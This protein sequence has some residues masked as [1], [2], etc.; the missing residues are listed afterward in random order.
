MRKC[1]RNIAPRPQTG[2]RRRSARAIKC[3]NGSCGFESLRRCAMCPL[4][5]ATGFVRS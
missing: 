4:E 3:E 1:E 5:R 2:Q